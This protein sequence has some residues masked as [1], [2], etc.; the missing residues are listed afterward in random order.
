MLDL[1]PNFFQKFSLDGSPHSTMWSP[2]V[3]SDWSIGNV[4]INYNPPHDTFIIFH[5]YTKDEIF[6]FAN[7]RIKNPR[8]TKKHII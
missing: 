8:N 5:L 7:I 3:S 1:K 4:V 6:N 2:H